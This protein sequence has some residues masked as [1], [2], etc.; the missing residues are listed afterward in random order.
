MEETHKYDD[1]INM[2]HPTS[3]V[4]PR[5]DAITRAAQFAP[6]K[7]LTGLEDEVEE[8]TMQR[9]VDAENEI[10][11]VQEYDDYLNRIHADSSVTESEE[12]RFE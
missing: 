6:F 3:K 1:I 10:E 4:H 11:H 5:M 12:V 7:A 2:E 8:T 9:I